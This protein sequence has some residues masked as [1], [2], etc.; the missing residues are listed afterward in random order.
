MPV[1]AGQRL[2]RIKLLVDGNEVP[3]D[4]F[5]LNDIRVEDVESVEL[6]TSPSKWAIYRMPV[7]LVTTRKG[8]PKWPVV[9][10][11]PGLITYKP[12]GYYNARTFYSPQYDTVQSSAADLRTTVFWTPNL[13]LDESGKVKLDYF[14]TDKPGNYRIVL[15][16]IDSDGKLARKTYSYKV[17]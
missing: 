15:E 12:K 3:P 7:M 4:G 10:Y 11:A 17:N 8:A 6:L 16:G 2:S 14:N 9:K 13:V 1:P 5:T